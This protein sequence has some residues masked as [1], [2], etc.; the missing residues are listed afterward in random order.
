MPNQPAK[1]KKWIS[2]LLNRDVI[3]RLEKLAKHRG[4]TRS[5]IIA[6]LLD[7]G[8]RHVELTVEDMAEIIKEMNKQ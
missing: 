2:A 3:K 4:K 6:T 1:D 5:E 8:T 7:E